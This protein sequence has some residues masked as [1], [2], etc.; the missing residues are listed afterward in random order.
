MDVI[1][2]EEADRWVRGDRFVRPFVRRLL[3]PSQPYLSGMQMVVRN[4]LR[5]L[6]RRGIT[7][8]FNPLSTRI[9]RTQPVISFGLGLKGVKGLKAETPIIAAIGFP[10]PAELPDLCKEY[11]IRKYLQHSQWVLQL[12]KS[13]GL[14]DPAI[15]DLWPAG[16][17]TEE[18]AVAT[19][20]KTVDILIYNKVYAH[21]EE[22]QTA[23]LDTIRRYL[24]SGGYSFIELRYRSYTPAQYRSALAQAKAMIFL[25]PHESQGMAYQE[26]LSSDVPVLAWDQG[27]WLDPTRSAYGLPPVRAT[28]VPFFDER[29]GRTFLDAADFETKFGGFIDDVRAKKF[30][31]REFVLE[32]VS[33][34]RSTERML[35]IY[36]S[37]ANA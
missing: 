8:R 2:R 3:R 10:Y 21:L 26:C 34:E 27:Y 11:N 14:Y 36:R 23:L 24:S 31:P 25:S 7:Y 13:A 12:A 6:D 29:C 28:S 9:G 16:I 17:D 1:Y 22:G 20:P 4:F 19:A 33:I 15:F 5:G 18:W 30:S 35:D 32:N 37:V